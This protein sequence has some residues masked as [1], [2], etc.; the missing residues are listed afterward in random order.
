MIFNAMIFVSGQKLSAS[1]RRARLGYL[2]VAILPI[3]G[4]LGLNRGWSIPHW[5]CPL[6]Y[7]T[8]IP[9]P[10][11]GLTRSFMAIARG[12]W[13]QAIAYHGLGWLLFMAF[14][15]AALH[16]GLELY[17]GRKITT[18]Y[19]PLI[20]TPKI[21]VLLFLVL[22]SYHAMRLYPM[23]QSGILLRSFAQSPLGRALLCQLEVIN[24]P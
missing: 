16:I 17:K 10:A 1:E 11:W 6:L 19:G 2:A 14:I 12:E 18:F 24:I 22:L 8:G 20:H 15:I 4:S 9:C 23:A 21:Q 3:I 5:G 13:Q 7:W